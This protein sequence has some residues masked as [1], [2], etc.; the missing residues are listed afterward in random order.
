LKAQ[1][2]QYRPAKNPRRN[3]LFPIDDDSGGLSGLDGGVRSLMRT[4]LHCKF[5]VNREKY[6]ETSD[7]HALKRLGGAVPQWFLT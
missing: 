1:S 3:G 5:P 6:R 2:R 4:G 7:F